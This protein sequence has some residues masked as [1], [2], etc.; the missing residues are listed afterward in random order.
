MKKIL[1]VLLVSVLPYNVV[2]KFDTLYIPADPN[3]KYTVIQY[4]KM[5]S[6]VLLQTMRRSSR[7]VSFDARLFNCSDST[8]I[9][10]TFKNLVRDK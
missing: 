3:A 9:K 1:L 2:A 8:N 6:L 4:K 5:G 10:G 7:G